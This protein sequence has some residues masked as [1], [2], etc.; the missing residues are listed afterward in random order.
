MGSCC[1]GEFIHTTSLNK[2]HIFGNSQ[3]G[4]NFLLYL[5][6]VVGA[7]LVIKLTQVRLT[8]EKE[9]NFNSCAWRYHKNDT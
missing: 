9:T 2:W 8:G 7:R 4:E 1:L 3:G 6:G 5:S